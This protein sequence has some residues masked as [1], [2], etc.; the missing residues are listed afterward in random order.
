VTVFKREILI[1]LHP[2]DKLFILPEQPS[3]VFW[4][5]KKN[6]GRFL[7]RCTQQG[8]KLGF[9]SLPRDSILDNID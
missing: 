8:K 7:R 6:I 4:G 3:D 1:R 5:D 9:I 2:N